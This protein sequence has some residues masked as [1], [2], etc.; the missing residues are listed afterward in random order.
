M[1]ERNKGD[2][3]ELGLQMSLDANEV[4]KFRKALIRILERV[5]VQDSNQAQQEDIKE[6]FK[7]LDYFSES[8]NTTWILYKFRKVSA[9][10]VKLH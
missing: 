10:S 1:I 3:K 9:I 4:S 5:E 2:T 7:L 8:K 6:I